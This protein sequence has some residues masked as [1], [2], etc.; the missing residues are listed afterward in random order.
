[1]NIELLLSL[2]ENSKIHRWEDKTR[3]LKG[4]VQKDIQ[5]RLTR[6]RRSRF[7][8]HRALLE[9]HQRPETT[10]EEKLV[11]LISLNYDKVVMLPSKTGHL[12]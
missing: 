2:I 11:A 4:L 8:L 12:A 5:A 6:S 7:Y 1:M 9:F 10:K 3:Y